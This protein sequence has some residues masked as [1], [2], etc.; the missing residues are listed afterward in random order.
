MKE[1]GTDDPWCV[2]V[3]RMAFLL[4][5]SRN[6]AYQMVRDGRIPSVRLGKR[7]LVPVV[8]LEKLLQQK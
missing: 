3:E 4:G 2:S 5:I 6:A 8:E 7:L 1:K